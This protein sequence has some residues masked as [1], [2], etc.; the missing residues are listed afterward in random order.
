MKPVFSILFFLVSVALGV[1][2]QTAPDFKWGNTSYFSLNIGD[3]IICDSTSVILLKIENQY[4]TLTAGNDTIRI[5]VSGRSLPGTANG[6]QLFVADNK[7]IKALS[8]NR[9]IHGLLK[10]DVLLGVAK[11][12]NNLLD[13]NQF[14]F[15]ISFNHGFVWHGD[16]ESYMYSFVYDDKKKTYETYPGIGIDLSDAK[17]FEKHWL[18]AIENSTVAWVEKQKDKQTACVLI[19]SEAFPGI[20]YVYDCLYEKNLEVRDGQKLE[21]GE[22]IGTAWGNAEWGHVH[23]AVVYSDTIPSYQDRFA[24]CVNFFPQL[25][26]L[27]FGNS[28]IGAKSY[29][30]GQINFGRRPSHSG[31]EKNNTAFEEYLGKGWVFDS[32]NRADKLETVFRGEEG[33]VRLRKKIFSGLSAQSINPN[34]YFDYEIGVRN[35]LYR[36]RSKV[37]D[38]KTETW[39]KVEYEGVTSNTF[40]LAAGEQKWTDERIVKV[41]DRKLTVRIYIDPSNQKPAGLSEI[42]FQMVYK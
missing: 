13:K 21:K 35:G 37:G 6:L 18:V 39:Q 38:V 22:L 42:V 2:G 41:E 24:N 10:K 29:S 26:E 34:N 30:K 17:G 9:S 7:W 25:Y 14:V 40:A 11:I 4:N 16:E 36:I 27:Y 8:D 32:W 33:N 3:S 12:S 1:A 28:Y 15:P 20:F 31:N 5:K 19:Q 23:L